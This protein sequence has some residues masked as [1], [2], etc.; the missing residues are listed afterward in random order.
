MKNKVLTIL[1]F[2]LIATLIYTLATMPDP[3]KYGQCPD[4]YKLDKVVTSC[5]PK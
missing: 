5:Q 1:L 2:I 3:Y 4:G